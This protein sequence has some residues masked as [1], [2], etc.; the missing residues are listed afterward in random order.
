MKI[1]DIKD[2]EDC[3]DGSL[4][5]EFLFNEPVSKDFIKYFGKLG[6]LE[7]FP[8]FARPFYRIDR[9]NKF[10]IK[11]VEGNKTARI[12]IASRIFQEMLKEIK[13]WIENF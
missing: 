13:D 10:V 4:I 9:E 3:F 5:K 2:L 6:K 7:Y 11:G 8:D 1:I 12:T